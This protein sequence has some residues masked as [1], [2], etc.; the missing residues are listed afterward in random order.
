MESRAPLVLTFLWLLVFLPAGLAQS[1]SQS[2]VSDYQPSDLASMDI[3][4]LMDLNVT[5][6]SRFEDKLSDAP[7]IMSVVT[8]DELL[9][10]GG[11]TLGEI[12]QRVPGLTG[13]TQNF[14]DRSM[15][16][17]RGDQTGTDGSHILFLINGRPTREVME[18]GIISDLLESFPVAILERI[19]VIRGPGSVLYGSNAYSAVINL[20]T[21]T[22][23]SHRATSVAL[24]GPNG[25]VA[26][27]TEFFYKRGN[28]NAVGA[29]QLHDAPDWPLTYVVPPSQRDLPFAPHVPTVQDVDIADRGVGAYA[30]LEY[31]GLSFMSS[32]TEWQTTGFAQGTVGE[33]RLT[34]AFANLG[35]DHQVTPKWD[36]NFN[37]TFTRTTFFEASYPSVV[38]NSDEGI[39]EYTNLFTL[40]SKDRLTAGIL[41]NRVEGL[42]LYTG[43]SPPAVTAEG[44]RPGGAFYAQIDHQLLNNLKLIAGFQSN[45]IGRIPL[46]TVPRFGAIW[47]PTSRT[48]LKAL[49][50]EAFRAPSLDETLLNRPGIA[51]NP[52][53]KPEK[54]A[55]FDL[56]FG[57]Q[58]DHIQLGLD[59][60]HSHLTDSIVTSSGLYTNLGSATFN[61]FEVEGKFFFWKDFFFQGSTLYQANHNGTGMTN[62]TPIPNLGY[63]AGI[64][65]EGRSGFTFGLFDVSDGPVTPFP[66]SV[67]PVQGWHN[68][69]NGNFAYDLT[70]HLPFGDRNKIELV[71]HGNNL[72]NQKVWLPG[73]GFAN[74]DQVPVQ[75]GFVFYAGFQVSL[76]KN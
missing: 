62:V 60:F 14:T 64:S 38:R 61:G 21:Q 3:E 73:W 11:M 32:F 44:R 55:T 47:A 6:A 68:I 27:S 58:A 71:M 46:N 19:E 65:Y 51:G 8:R 50:G 57:Y 74:V 37:L 15:V 26:S 72:L 52:N 43:V 5:T 67:N 63:K 69:L 18:G 30:G 17:A 20:I 66:D 45:K 22:P 39:I 34:R 48:S 70:R 16:A 4:K 9:R 49:F 41:A 1:P 24:G 31:K 40:S 13:T 53:L 23:D 59:F 75:Q 36:A 76:G 33:T 56:G 29:A 10:F 28:F 25:A 54:I 35:Y 12:L 7:G 42:E 2:N